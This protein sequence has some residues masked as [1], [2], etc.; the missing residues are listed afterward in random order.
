VAII[1]DSSTSVSDPINGGLVQVNV[2]ADTGIN[3][4]GSAPTNRVE[5]VEWLNTTSKNRTFQLFSQQANAA[6]SVVLPND[7]PSL[8]TW[9]PPGNRKIDARATW[10]K[11]I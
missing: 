9:T 7:T 5:R 4:D 10:G 11:L 6:V 3:S 8:Q 2:Y 1:L